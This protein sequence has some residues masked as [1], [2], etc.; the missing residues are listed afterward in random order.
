MSLLISIGEVSALDDPA[1]IL[2]RL[3]RDDPSG[4]W[5][6]II[7]GTVD[8]HESHDRDDALDDGV[9][10]LLPGMAAPTK[11]KPLAVAAKRYM[12][13]QGLRVAEKK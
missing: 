2:S 11:P 12:Q 7:M 8:Y 4:F 3:A 6:A 5:T 1:A 13:S 9:A 10:V